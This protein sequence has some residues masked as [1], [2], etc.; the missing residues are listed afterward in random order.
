MQE[1]TKGLLIQ[2]NDIFNTEMYKTDE[3]A[4]K[5]VKKETDIENAALLDK[6][7]IRKLVQKGKVCQKIIINLNGNNKKSLR[8]CFN[9][10]IFSCHVRLYQS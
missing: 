4:K 10:L 3:P 1:L 8:T 2:Y 7:S 6:E 9:I 5:K